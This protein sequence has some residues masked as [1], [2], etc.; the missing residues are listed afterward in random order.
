MTP[1]G[2][3]V[4]VGYFQCCDNYAKS[5]VNPRHLWTAHDST[6][7]YT[8]PEGWNDHAKSCDRDDCEV[9]S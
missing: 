3:S 9:V 6:R 5:D 1:L 4:P 2:R 7:W 8:D